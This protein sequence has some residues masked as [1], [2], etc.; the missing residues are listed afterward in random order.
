MKKLYFKRNVIVLFLFILIAGG[1][2]AQS[3]TEIIFIYDPNG[4]NPD[5]GVNPDEETAV[6][7]MQE[8]G[9]MVT[10]FPVVDLSTATPDV[11]ETLNSADLIYIGRRVGSTNFQDPN[12]QMWNSIEAP[13][14]TG[15]MWALRSNRMNW[16]NSE[17]CVGGGTFGSEDIVWVD[18]LE[19][20]D[21]VFADIDVYEGG[22]WIGSYNVI[23]VDDAGNGLV[24]CVETENL[25]PVFVR[26]DPGLDFYD[27]AGDYPEGPRTFMG[28]DADNS[29][30]SEFNYCAYT[31]DA[32]QV[33]LNEIARLTGNLEPGSSERLSGVK[34]SVNFNQSNGQLVVSMDQLSK[35]EV[36]DLLG[37]QVLSS[38]ANNEKMQIDLSN[39]KSG[40]HIVKLANSNNQFYTQKILI[41]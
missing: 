18:V 7:I 14:M 22:W 6:A 5:T 20:D 1:V 12:K 10:L 30:A 21:P 31:D 27:G 17:S 19:E 36:F 39:I 4:L 33:F 15:N 3:E 40:L 41:K 34:A 38:P 37:R 35:I 8:A 29:G 26:F 13:I 24:M 32:K 23:E 2:Y 25:R 9:Y 11:L 16:F 28:M